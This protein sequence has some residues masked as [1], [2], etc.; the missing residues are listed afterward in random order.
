MSLIDLSDAFSVALFP[1]VDLHL[2]YDILISD[3]EL[4]AKCVLHPSLNHMVKS[5]TILEGDFIKASY[6]SLFRLY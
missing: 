3:K 4:G 5:G 1:D 2:L 6:S